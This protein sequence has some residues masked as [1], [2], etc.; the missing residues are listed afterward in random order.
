MEA[1]KN[2][3][4]GPSMIL[5]GA[6]S[7]LVQDY[8]ESVLR[9]G[10]KITAV[11]RLGNERVRVLDKSIVVPLD[12]AVL[13]FNGSS[14]IICGLSPR[15]RQ[16]NVELAQAYGFKISNPLIDPT[17][18]L[19][20]TVRVAPGSFVNAGV[21]IGSLTHLGEH[22]IINRSANIGHHVI[23]Q[24]FANIGPGVTVTGA[25]RIGKGAFVGAGAV[26]SGGVSIGQNAL[27]AAGTVV[28]RSVPDDH[29]VFGNPPKMR[30]IMRQRFLETVEDN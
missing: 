7:P 26:L 3:L 18:I 13:R 24:D 30:R 2:E 25:T 29:L 23:I 10:D 27:V 17:A 20:S 15:S 12:E 4:L 16:A 8:L 6:S 22:V 11:L 28:R 21:V 9:L 5:L 19:A 14:I 1:V